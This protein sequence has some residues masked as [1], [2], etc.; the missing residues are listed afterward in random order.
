MFFKAT[1]QLLFDAGWF[2][3]FDKRDVFFGDDSSF[4]KKRRAVTKKIDDDAQMVEYFITI[5]HWEHQATP[6]F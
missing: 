4:N 2:D 6:D 3:N 5:H 1:I